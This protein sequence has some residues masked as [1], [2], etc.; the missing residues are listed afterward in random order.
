MRIN[1]LLGAYRR[2]DQAS[3]RP[4]TAGNSRDLEAAVSDI[5]D[6]G[7]TVSGQ[8]TIWRE[9]SDTTRQAQHGTRPP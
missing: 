3:N 8:A 7:D 4:L 1:Y 9:T 6:D 2:L 5:M